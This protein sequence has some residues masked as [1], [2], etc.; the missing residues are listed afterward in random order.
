MFWDIRNLSA[1][2][3]KE[4][5]IGPLDFSVPDGSF[6]AVIGRNGSGKS[7]LLSCL[8]GL[9]SYRGEILVDGVS[10]SH[11]RG[12][13]RARRISLL[14]QHIRS[15]HICVE[16]LVR[17]GRNPYLPLGGKLSD[18]DLF[19]VEEAMRAAHLMMLRTRYVDT[20][21]GGEKRRAYLGMTLSQDAPTMLLDEATANMDLCIE[22]QFWQIVKK[23]QCEQGKTVI[24]VMHNLS[25]AVRLADRIVLL[26]H[27]TLC[28]AGTTEDFLMTSLPEEVLFVRRTV[29]KDGVFFVGNGL[30]SEW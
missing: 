14:P 3:G 19:H 11:L 23:R 9:R 7:T 30:I 2:Y 17:F 18:G 24:A 5:A 13:E 10:L 21:S 25:D 15:P 8:A 20:L 1:F 29:T 12:R 22:A 6:T 28:F 27:G 4:R 26:D 16:T